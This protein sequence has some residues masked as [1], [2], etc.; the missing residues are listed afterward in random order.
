MLEI[1]LPPRSMFLR[2]PLITFFSHIAAKCIG[3]ARVTR[4]RDK[5]EDILVLEC[6]SAH[7][8]HKAVED[9]LISILE[10]KAG[11]APYAPV[12]EMRNKLQALR[13]GEIP[14]GFRCEDVEVD[15]LVECYL[16]NVVRRLDPEEYVKQLRKAFDSFSEGYRDDNDYGSYSPPSILVPESVEAI[17]IF[18][19]TNSKGTQVYPRDVELRK[20]IKLGFHSIVTG[21]AG[22]WL[23]GIHVDIIRGMHSYV[24]LASED[25]TKEIVDKFDKLIG[26]LKAKSLSDIAIRVLATLVVSVV[27]G[28]VVYTEFVGSKYRCDLTKFDVVD[29]DK[30]ATLARRM[31]DKLRER[32]IAAIAMG[33]E[34]GEEIAY[35]LFIATTLPRQRYSA[36]FIV[37]RKSLFGEDGRL[38]PKDLS[39]LLRVLEIMW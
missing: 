27:G 14:T 33:G 6:P 1:A 29:L 28:R 25:V 15:D 22:L 8:L 16:K 23:G 30:L 3:I 39:E 36:F 10:G 35:R 34:L 12:R 21:L 38:A 24:L 2:Y 11:L 18:G 20:R 17:R 13:L 19:A 26:Y 37:A 4:R 31:D 5:L 9:I 32:L 7:N